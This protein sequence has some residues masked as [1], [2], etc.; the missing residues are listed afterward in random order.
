MRPTLTSKCCADAGCRE[1]LENRGHKF[2]HS[3][4]NDTSGCHE[5]WDE[6]PF[7]NSEHGR[8]ISINY[9]IKNRNTIWRKLKAFLGVIFCPERAR[10]IFF[11][12][13]VCFFLF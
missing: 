13:F 3:L 7:G 4:L 2:Y 8:L 10:L 1:H 9:V 11:Q 5:I 6:K 12:I